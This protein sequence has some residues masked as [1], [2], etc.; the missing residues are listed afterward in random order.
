LGFPK[1]LLNMDIAALATE[2]QNTCNAKQQQKTTTALTSKFE[3]L[4]SSD[5]DPTAPTTVEKK[6]RARTW[7][8]PAPPTYATPTR[9]K[10]LYRG[11]GRDPSR[12]RGPIDRDELSHK[13]RARAQI[14]NPPPLLSNSLIAGQHRS[15]RGGSSRSRG[16]EGSEEAAYRI[17]RRRARGLGGRK[18]GGREESGWKAA[19]GGELGSKGRIRFRF[20]MIG[21]ETSWSWG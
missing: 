17:R 20:L 21:G 12:D 19:R 14:A 8:R 5:P 9:R 16:R 7:R 1:I 11:S 2:T 15:G 13:D 3:K 10:P 4:K 18:R 6:K